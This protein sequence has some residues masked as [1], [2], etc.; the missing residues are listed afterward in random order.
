MSEFYDPPAV[1][2]AWKVTQLF[3]EHPR[4]SSKGLGFDAF[5][6]YSHERDHLGRLITAKKR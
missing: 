5:V 2:S 6:P 4:N 1:N 3:E